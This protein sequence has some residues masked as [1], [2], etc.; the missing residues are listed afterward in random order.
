MFDWGELERPGPE[1][2]TVDGTELRRG[3]R[4]RLQPR[5]RGDIFDTALAGMTAVIEAI[6][7]NMEDQI[8]LA[9]VL[10]DD[11]GRHLGEERQPGHR[12]FF[13]PEEVEPLDPVVPEQADATAPRILLAGIGNLFLGDDGFGV[14]MASRLGW[15]QL[16]AGV[17]VEDFGIRGMDLAYELGAGYDAAILIDATPRGQAPGTLYVI[18]PE[19]EDGAVPIDVH[20]MDPVKVLGLARTLGELPKRILVVGCEPA[21]RMSA[22]DEDVVAELSEP[23]RASLARAE[24]LVMDLLDDLRAGDDEREETVG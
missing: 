5:P 12:F 18:E 13:S 22:D 1:A 23:V 16:P 7:Q 9:V 11:P 17:R 24:R 21:T 14:E 20:G 10:E 19:L 15:R 6:E 4:V 2:I 3:S 8:Q